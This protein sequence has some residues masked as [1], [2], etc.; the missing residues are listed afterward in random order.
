MEQEAP[1]KR[2]LDTV[3]SEADVIESVQKRKKVTLAP[4]AEIQT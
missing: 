4:N 3:T 1:Q 2:S